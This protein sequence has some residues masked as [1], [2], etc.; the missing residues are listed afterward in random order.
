MQDKLKLEQQQAI[1]AYDKKFYKLQREHADTLAHQNFEIDKLQNQSKF[2]QK[3]AAAIVQLVEDEETARDAPR[4]GKQNAE[5][6]KLINESA[7]TKKLG[8]AV[9]ANVEAKE[10]FKEAPKAGQENAM[11]TA[12]QNETTRQKTRNQVPQELFDQTLAENYKQASTD[13]I[14]ML[15]AQNEYRRQIVEGRKRLNERLVTHSKTFKKLQPG[16]V[17][18]HQQRNQILDELAKVDSIM[19]DL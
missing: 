9:T 7:H 11:L 1:N 10:G 4:R 6:T 3:E 19:T 15:N 17:Q 13:F 5:V 16:Y 18:T 12:L 2:K 8:D 14:S